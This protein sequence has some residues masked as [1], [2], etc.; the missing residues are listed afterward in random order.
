MKAE[1]QEDVD[2]AETVQRLPTIL[3][4]LPTAYIADDDETQTIRLG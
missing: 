4:V 3:G 1:D 2:D